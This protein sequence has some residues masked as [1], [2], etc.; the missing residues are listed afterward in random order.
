L[1]ADFAKNCAHKWKKLSPEE[2]QHF[3]QLSELDR[4]RYEKEMKTYRELKK[5][6]MDNK[7][8]KSVENCCNNEDIS[9]DPNDDISSNSAFDLF[10]K[11]EMPI[12]RELMPNINNEEMLNELL[13]RWNSSGDEIKKKFRDCLRLEFEGTDNVKD[14]QEYISDDNEYDC[15]ED[16]VVDDYDEEDIHSK[17]SK[18]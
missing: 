9:Y 15:D 8:K 16:E 10:A 1:F 18:V 12:V 14:I 17:S 11:Q 2:K 6:K 5:K 4:I 13:R 7:K 3:H